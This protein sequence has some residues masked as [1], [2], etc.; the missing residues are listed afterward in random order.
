MGSLVSSLRVA[1][2]TGGNNS[3]PPV[4]M[5]PHGSSGSTL[6]LTYPKLYSL[7]PP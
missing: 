1:V 7:S 2:E 3:F 6:Y 4:F 5:Y